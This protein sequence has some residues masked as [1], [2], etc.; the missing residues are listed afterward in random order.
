MSDDETLLR[1]ASRYGLTSVP[2]AEADEL[3][4]GANV[5]LFLREHL[6]SR[7]I[8][9]RF[10]AAKVLFVPISSFDTELESALYTLRLTFLTDYAAAVERTRRW[11]DDLGRRTEPISFVSKGPCSSGGPGTNFVCALAD[12]LTLDAWAS[13]TIGAGQWV[14]VGSYCEL[15]VTGR[16]PAANRPHPFTIDGTAVASGVLAA[17]DPRF[18][19]AGDARI[20]AA[21]DLRRELARRAPIVLRLKGGVLA[22]AR[23]DGEDFTDAL[24]EATNP[25]YGLH[26]LELGL[27][28]NQHVLPHVDWTVNSQLN[29]GAGPVHIGFGDGITGA[30]MDFVVAEAAHHFGSST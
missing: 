7:E 1:E 10:R 8:R 24:R 4:A 14:G 28:T 5:V 18:D 25:E 12:D 23:A 9:K 29:E 2:M 16:G 17:R 21:N 13:P 26:A 27:G 19:D 30:H 22:E 3:P 20:R 11:I 15:A 6:L